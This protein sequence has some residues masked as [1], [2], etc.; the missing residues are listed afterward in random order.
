MK[1]KIIYHKKE[2]LL[3]KYFENITKATA[4]IRYLKLADHLDNI[5]SLK[6]SAH[7]DKI[8]RY[9][10]EAQRYVIPLAQKTDEKIV[11]KLSVALYELK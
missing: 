6:N 10:E 5:R 2:Q 4:A 1:P 11:F 8:L 7:K 3:N 9:K